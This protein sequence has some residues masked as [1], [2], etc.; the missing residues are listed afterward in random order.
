MAITSML[1]EASDVGFLPMIQAQ[2]VMLSFFSC[3]GGTS[4]RGRERHHRRKL[5]AARRQLSSLLLSHF[6]FLCVILILGFAK[7]RL[8]H[9]E[10]LAGLCGP[11]FCEMLDYRK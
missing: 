2:F 10:A 11:T 3:G 5:I 4:R 8:P 1:Q 7:L 9:P 6:Y